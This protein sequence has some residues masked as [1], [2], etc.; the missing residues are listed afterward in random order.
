MILLF[1]IAVIQVALPIGLLVWLWRGRPGNRAAWLARVLLA[2]GVIGVTAVAGLWLVPPWPTPFIYLV[3]WLALS[4]A[5]WRRVRARPWLPRE[6]WR[7]WTSLAATGVA[8]FASLAIL[9][10]AV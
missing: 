6:G 9:V 7:A 3:L 1:W 5:E 10:H 2:G 4:V 8:A